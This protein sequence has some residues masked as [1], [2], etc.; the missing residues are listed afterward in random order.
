MG[1]KFFCLV[2]FILLFA[3]IV[4]N[5][6]VPNAPGSS[7]TPL[8]PTQTS[9]PSTS[10]PSTEAPETL[11]APEPTHEG[12]SGPLFVNPDNRRYFTDGVKVNGKYRSIY[13][14]GAHTWCNLIDCGNSNPPITFDYER[15]LDFV[16]TNNY[17]FFRLWR[18]ENARGG[19]AGADFWFAP[20]PYERS[21]ECCAFDGGN[22][23]DLEK[24]NQAYFDRMRERVIQAGERGIYVSIML[25]DGWSVESKFNG[26]NPW[27][28]HPYNVE[29]NINHIN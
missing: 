5:G 15:Y 17:N 4:G 21:D 12:S 3:A 8:A 23:F 26:H 25:F 2:R 11:V 28:G 19:E 10:S 13:L 18:A 1:K 27:V 20:M 7:H 9:V 6:C 14:T 29:N 16:Q 24:F 22:K